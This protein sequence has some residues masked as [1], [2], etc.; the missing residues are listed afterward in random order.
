[1]I[2]RLRA[3]L[4]YALRR[5]LGFPLEELALARLK[6]GGLQPRIVFDVGASHGLFVDQLWKHWP[7]ASVHCFEPEPEYQAA[8]QRRARERPELHLCRALVGSTNSDAETYNYHLG[9]RPSL[10]ARGTLGSRNR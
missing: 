5:R 7:G 8:L 2:A 3:R 10:P 1:M 6:R 4:A 9:H